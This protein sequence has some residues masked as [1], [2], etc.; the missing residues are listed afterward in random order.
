MGVDCSADSLH[1]DL[2]AITRDPIR[3]E[4][5][6][7]IYPLHL[8]LRVD[9]E[10]QLINNAMPPAE[11]PA[12]WNAQSEKLMGITP[13]DDLTG[14]LQD[15][16]LYV[17]YIGYFPC[18]LLGFMAA[19]QLGAAMVRT[20]PFV[21]ADWAAGDFTRTNAWLA[22]NVY[23]HGRTLSPDALMEKATGAMLSSAALIAH[24]QNRY[25]QG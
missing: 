24:L 14:C 20:H 11:L 9:I 8:Q 4:A 19:A 5:R 10:E 2:T 12:Y 18:Y 7:A 15:I 17:G 23:Q 6:E 25:V 22:A 1:R 3:A 13:P 21:A 16:H